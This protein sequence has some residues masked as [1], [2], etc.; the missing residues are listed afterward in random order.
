MPRLCAVGATG[1]RRTPLR[2]WASFQ[3]RR[4]HPSSCCGS[5]GARRAGQTLIG[6][7]GRARR[8]LGV[9]GAGPTLIACR[10]GGAGRFQCRVNCEAFPE[11][12]ALLAGGED[13]WRL[14]R[15]WGDWFRER[16]PLCAPWALRR[17]LRAVPRVD[18]R[19]D[20]SR[21]IY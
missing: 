2:E 1:A 19:R 8:G 10:W 12:A 6:R 7:R 5:I 17:V 16:S 9:Y 18:A 14:V 13:T 3:L 11:V 20:Q 15:S 4:L 21:C